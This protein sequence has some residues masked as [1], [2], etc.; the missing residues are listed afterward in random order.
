[1]ALTVAPPPEAFKQGDYDPAGYVAGQ[2]ATYPQPKPPATLYQPVMWWLSIGT[3]TMDGWPVA[4]GD[5]IFVVQKARTFG[6]FKFGD[7]IFGG[8]LP[9][10]WPAGLV[11][12][13]AY[14]HTLPAEQ[15][16]PWPNAGC[17]FTA[18]RSDIPAGNWAPGWRIVVDAL[19]NDLVGSRTYGQL[20]YGDEVYGDEDA[21]RLRWVDITQPMYQIGV[22]VGTL[23]G[24][25]AVPVTEIAITLL[26]DTGEWFDYSVPRIWYQPDLGT[27]IRIGFFDPQFRYRPVCIGELETIRDDHDTLPREVELLGV[28]RSTELVVT[29]TGWQRPAERTATRFMALLGAAGWRWE[30]YSLIFP[31]PDINLHADPAP[32]SI[33]VRDE[34][35]RTAISAGWYVD[36]DRWGGIRARRFPHEPA[37][38]PIVVT[39]CRHDDNPD[40]LLS[41]SIVF[42]RDQAQVINMASFENSEQQRKAATATDPFSVARFGLRTE[43]MGF[44]HLGLAFADA[45]DAQAVVQRVVSRFGY[46]SRHVEDI[47]ADTDVDHGWLPVLTELDTGLPLTVHRREV[48]ELVLDGVVVGYS[49]IIT[50]G[51]I[52]TT[53][54]T[55]TITAT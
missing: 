25:P 30:N 8:N 22:A 7:Y 35:D 33:N 4:P 23:D 26:D 46:I 17:P 13:V 21:A 29:V 19:Y 34:L 44:P 24:A 50:P 5:Y 51:R 6:Q 2:P 52:V 54:S 41:P 15:V 39:D 12:F 11:G 31:N 45:A 18:D 36:E 53:I 16:P 27:P 37:G 28:S 55:T 47:T 43:A 40:E 9:R 1:V 38:P 10:D 20:N 42:V 14:D 48:S 49:H 3:G 32:Q